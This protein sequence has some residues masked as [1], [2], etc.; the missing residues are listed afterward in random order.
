MAIPEEDREIPMDME[1]GSW[2]KWAE[3]SNAALP[4]GKGVA[5]PTA[6]PERVTIQKAT[7]NRA[8]AN[9]V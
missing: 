2:S 7:D 1:T 5:A 4:A 9:F 8:H 6:Q 3:N